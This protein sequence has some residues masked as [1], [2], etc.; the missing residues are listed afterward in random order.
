MGTHSVSTPSFIFC[1][2]RTNRAPCRQCADAGDLHQY[3]YQISYIYFTL[4]RN[5]IA[6]YQACFAPAMTSAAIKWAK[7]HVDEFNNLLARQISKLQKDSEEWNYCIERAKEHAGM[8]GEVGID[9]KGLIGRGV[10]T[11]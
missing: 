11:A 3:L 2:P 6:I 1:S 4:I 5:T 9:F 7:E 8:L 10:G